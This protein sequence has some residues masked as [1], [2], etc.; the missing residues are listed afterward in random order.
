MF[1]CRPRCTLLFRLIL[2]MFVVWF[3]VVRR[4][5]TVRFLCVSLFL[6]RL[7]VPLRRVLSRSVPVMV[8]RV[9]VILVLV[10]RVCPLL[11]VWLIVV[12]VFSFV[13]RCMIRRMRRVMRRRFWV[14]FVCLVLRIIV[15]L[16]TLRRRLTWVRVFL[17]RR[18]VR[19]FWIMLIM[20]RVF[21]VRLLMLC[22]LVISPMLWRIRLLIVV[23]SV[24]LIVILLMF[25]LRV[26]SVMR[27][28]VMTVLIIE[29]RLRAL[30]CFFVFRRIVRFVGVVVMVVVS[31]CVVIFRL[32]LL[33]FRLSLRRRVIRLSRV[34]PMI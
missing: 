24:F 34:L 33:L 1:G 19:R 30:R 18:V 31:V 28:R 15:L 2:M 22:R 17:R 7:F 27:R 9:L 26:F 21:I 10:R 13:V 14:I 20:R 16:I 4:V 5:L 29:V 32:R 6:R 25:I 3:G 11:D 12:R 8:F 23:L